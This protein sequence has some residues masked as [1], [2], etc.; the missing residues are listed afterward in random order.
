MVLHLA[1]SFLLCLGAALQAQAPTATLPP[2]SFEFG[3]VIQGTVVTHVFA[4][5]NPSAAPLRI[6][7]VD[8][9]P[10]LRIAGFPAQVGPN[11]QIDLPVSFST[12][13]MRGP[14][15]G[16]LR[17]RLD[18][19][20]RPH[21][22]FTMAGVVVPRVEFRPYAAFFLTGD[23]QTPARASIEIVNH[24]EAPLRITRHDYPR[25][26][27][28]AR[29]EPLEDGRRYRLSITLRTDAAAGVRADVIQLH[30]DDGR[31]LRIPAN[32]R[33]RERVYTFPAEVD[34]G[35]IAQASL[36]DGGADL[37]AQTLMVY[38]AGGEDFRAAF[39]TDVKGLA[40]AA[41]RGPK[42]DRWQ[43][44]VTLE[45]SASTA[46]RIQG[47]IVIE[48]NDPEFPRLVVPVKGSVLDRQA[49]PRK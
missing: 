32:T 33:L 43:A 22:V 2:S 15:S 42:G 1:A 18:D 14:Y 27:F 23:R 38:Q 11:Q 19:P 41:E 6:L 17:L 39:T 29:L 5:R 35:S 7:G 28:D 24:Q 40:I 49:G 20:G 25:D 21:A 36:D 47:S 34:L 48:T 3:T 13:G 37:P 26:R 16:E 45:R 4:L 46:G 10:G 31:V 9:S 44:T 8:L 12:S 30:A